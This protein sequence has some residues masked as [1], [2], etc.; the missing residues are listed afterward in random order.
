MYEM[1]LSSDTV[2]FIWEYKAAK[3]IIYLCISSILS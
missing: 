3:N 2:C 1:K